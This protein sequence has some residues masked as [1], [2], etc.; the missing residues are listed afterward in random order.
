MLKAKR[1]SYFIIFEEIKNTSY[2]SENNY[3]PKAAY[4]VLKK[5]YY[6]IVAG[7]VVFLL[8]AL[9]I[10]ENIHSEAFELNEPLNLVL[11]I[12]TLLSFTMGSAVSRRIFSSAKPEDE[13][14]KKMSTFQTGLI[15]RLATYEAI[16]LFSIVVFIMTGNSLV[17]LFALIS[18]F[19]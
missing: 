9:Y 3:D 17:L 18:L 2:M 16:E 7:P 12:L 4:S 10:T 14:R 19:F 15:I 1:K 5:I 6:A 11:I 13:H 8:L